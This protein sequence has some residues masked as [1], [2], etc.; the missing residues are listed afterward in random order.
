MTISGATEIP[1]ELQALRYTEVIV[2]VIPYFAQ[3]TFSRTF[4]QLAGMSSLLGTVNRTTSRR[5]QQRSFSRCLAGRSNLKPPQQPTR[6]SIVHHSPTIRSTFSTMVVLKSNAPATG[7]VRE[8]DPEIKYLASY[9]HNYKIDSDLA[10][11]D[12]H[13]KPA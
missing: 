7:G 13:S 10:V 2:K 6:T 11:C 9:I 12:P 8:F 3:L 5:L 4:H 1:S